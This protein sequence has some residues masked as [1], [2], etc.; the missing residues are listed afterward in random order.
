[1]TH[2]PLNLKKTTYI[3]YTLL[4]GVTV[5]KHL[6]RKST[7]AKEFRKTLLAFKMRE[8]LGFFL[9]AL[10]DNLHKLLLKENT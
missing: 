1:M 9:C 8:S 3:L 5:H 6:T 7:M 10:M 4:K 2:G